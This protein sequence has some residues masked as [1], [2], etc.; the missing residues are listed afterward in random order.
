MYS[1]WFHDFHF[2]YS[3]FLSFSFGR[4]NCTE[5]R[6]GEIDLAM[7]LAE[8]QNPHTSFFVPHTRPCAMWLLSRQLSLL[9][10]SRRDISTPH[11]KFS[12][13]CIDFCHSTFQ[14]RLGWSY[15]A[16]T[17]LCGMFEPSLCNL[18]QKLE[19]GI[20]YGVDHDYPLTISNKKSLE[21]IIL[22]WFLL[23]IDLISPFLHVHVTFVLP[24]MAAIMNTTK[25]RKNSG[26]ANWHDSLTQVEPL[27]CSLFEA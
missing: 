11:F 16:W 20:H 26:L 7:E 9:G 24:P 13:A 22:G 14:I 23:Y 8:I 25:R 21:S 15:S 6:R 5:V 19:T 27:P 4:A 12:D 2:C 3:K 17:I 10:D 18:K 1:A